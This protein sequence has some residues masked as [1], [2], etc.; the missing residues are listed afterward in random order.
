MVNGY[1]R[2]PEGVKEFKEI[3]L[4]YPNELFDN[5]YADF[6]KRTRESPKDKTKVEIRNMTRVLLADESQQYIVHDQE[7]I[8]FDMIGNLRPWYRGGIGRYPIVTPRYEIKVDPETYEKTRVCT[9]VSNIKCGY[10]I[11]FSP[12]KT[13]ELH[14][15]CLDTPSEYSNNMKTSYSVQRGENKG[16]GN[17]VTVSSYRD[18]R[19][20]EDIEELFRFGH[21][22][23]PE[24]RQLLADEKAGKIVSQQQRIAA[25]RPYL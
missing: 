1:C 11:K 9:G 22:A 20:A 18:W 16:P 5:S 23:S 21:I 4:E 2:S 19:D 10:S 8:R 6:L 25:N 15:L 24:E 3:G 17:L 14:K 12:K 13:D 7:D